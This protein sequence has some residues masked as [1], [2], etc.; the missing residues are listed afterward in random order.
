MDGIE[1]DLRGSVEVIRLDILSEFGR[2]IAG[3][4]RVS[5]VPALVIVDGQGRVAQQSAG[6]PNREAITGAALALVE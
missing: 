6:I 3:Q 1:A 2:Q 5:A 4:Y